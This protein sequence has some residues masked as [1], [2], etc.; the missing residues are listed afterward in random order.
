[1]VN[2]SVGKYYTPQGKS[3]TGVGITPDVELDLDDEQYALLYYGQLEAAD[4][5]QLQAAI[6]V[7]S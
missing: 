1:M 4:D 3:L 2:L 5:P 6:D 7:L